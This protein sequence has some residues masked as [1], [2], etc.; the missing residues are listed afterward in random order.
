[1]TNKLTFFWRWIFLGN[2]AAS[3]SRNIQTFV[4]FTFEEAVRQSQPWLVNKRIKTIILQVRALYWIPDFV[5]F[6]LALCLLLFWILNHKVFSSLKG[7]SRWWRCW[8]KRCRQ[9]KHLALITKK[10]WIKSDLSCSDL[11]LLT[12][13]HHLKRQNVWRIHV[14]KPLSALHLGSETQRGGRFHPYKTDF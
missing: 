9:N 7:E 12:F 5:C 11:L 3:N 8:K 14:K 6:G 10:S 4:L 2:Y 13:N 1:M